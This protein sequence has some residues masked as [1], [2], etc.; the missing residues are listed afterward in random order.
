ML[1]QRNSSL[2]NHCPVESNRCSR[3]WP[4]PSV[5]TAVVCM[6]VSTSLSFQECPKVNQPASSLPSFL[7]FF[8][9]LFQFNPICVNSAKD[10]KCKQ[11]NRNQRRS[12]TLKS[13][14]VQSTRSSRGAGFSSECSHWGSSQPPTTPAEGDLTTN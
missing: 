14:V 13:R 1:T 2:R 5:C 12:S 11:T 8:L 4:I 9:P 7:S 10:A 3:S 6:Q